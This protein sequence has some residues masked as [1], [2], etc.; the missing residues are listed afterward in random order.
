ML[1]NKVVEFASL[2]DHDLEALRALGY[3]YSAEH[4]QTIHEPPWL[5]HIQ[6][7]QLRKAIKVEKTKKGW[8][9]GIDEGIA[10]HAKFVIFGTEK[11]VSRDFLVEALKAIREDVRKILAE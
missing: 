8:R 11:M 6:S 4:P 9:V 1:Y 7:G 10:P 5:V 2:A 3:P